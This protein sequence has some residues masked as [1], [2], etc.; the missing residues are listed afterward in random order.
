MADVADDVHGNKTEGG[1]RASD[2]R[3]RS[4]GRFA[5][6]KEKSALTPAVTVMP[7]PERGGDAITTLSHITIRIVVRAVVIFV[8]E[9]E[10]LTSRGTM[11]LIVA[12][13]AM[14]AAL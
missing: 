8:L 7:L 4:R 13:V 1:R 14:D 9:S 11:S 2:F 6:Y 10:H 5:G 12:I 3:G